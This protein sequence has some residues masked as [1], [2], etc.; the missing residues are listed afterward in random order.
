M[1]AVQNKIRRRREQANKTQAQMADALSIHIKTYQKIENGI[2]RLDLER[3]DQIA[4]ILETDVEDLINVEDDVH[5]N[6]IKGN[7]VGFN[8]KDVVINHHNTDVKAIYERLIEEKD[9][10]IAEKNKEI[11]FLRGLVTKNEMKA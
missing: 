7:D 8:N 1:G 5:I 2:T 11:E 4:Q 6:E 3:L 9:F 10:I